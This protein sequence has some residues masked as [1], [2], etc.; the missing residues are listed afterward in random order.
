MKIEELSWLNLD[1]KQV[2]MISGQC[3]SVPMIYTDIDLLICPKKIINKY[4]DNL[5]PGLQRGEGKV[6]ITKE[7]SDESNETLRRKD[8]RRCGASS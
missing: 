3:H 4:I 5:K 6:I 7:K 1:G 2:L 8:K